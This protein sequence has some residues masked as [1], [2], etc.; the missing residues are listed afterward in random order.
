MHLKK[1]MQIPI[2]FTSLTFIYCKECWAPGE[3]GDCIVI[4]LLCTD[5]TEITMVC[6]ERKLAVVDACET[7]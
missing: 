5:V 1:D 7:T 2:L 6:G 4:A 3:V